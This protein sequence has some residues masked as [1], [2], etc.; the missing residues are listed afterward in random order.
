METGSPLD[1][2]PDL[3]PTVVTPL[4]LGASEL[5][6]VSNLLLQILS[7]LTVYQSLPDVPGLVLTVRD[8]VL[9][10][11]ACCLF[12]PCQSSTVVEI[13][14]TSTLQSPSA[15]DSPT[16]KANR[17]LAIA[18]SKADDYMFAK[19]LE[20]EASRVTSAFAA[21]SESVDPVGD[22]LSVDDVIFYL[23]KILRKD[24]PT[25]PDLTVRE[26]I[27][28]KRSA[29][30]RLGT[31]DDVA[32][33]KFCEAST[34]VQRGSLNMSQG[35][36]PNQVITG[37]SMNL[38]SSNLMNTEG[39]SFKKSRSGGSCLAAVNSL[40]ERPWQSSLPLTVVTEK[41]LT[42]V[43]GYTT[44]K[45]LMVHV[46]MNCSDRLL[47]PFFTSPVEFESLRVTAEKNLESCP[48][49]D[50]DVANLHDA[51][52]V[53]PTSLL[54]ILVAGRY[55]T[56]QGVLLAEEVLD[57]LKKR[58][59][60]SEELTSLKSVRVR[61]I[62]PATMPSNEKAAV[63]HESDFPLPLSSLLQTLLMSYAD[64]I[65]V[66]SQDEVPMGVVTSRDIWGY[67]MQGT[68]GES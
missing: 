14:P 33:V 49:L 64:A 15:G 43:F 47:E 18:S 27:A 57:Q 44:M 5:L 24:D 59:E 63:L 66:L 1:T 37:S 20:N 29:V 36:Q 4:D 65:I 8:D 48:F 40:L 45:Q 25:I 52:E 12:L 30:F 22:F 9:M 54:A 67:V 56:Y 61:S 13:L 28:G 41:C 19:A 10:L 42:A 46:A 53:L 32:W 7:R 39:S 17:L 50:F 62:M 16:S 21:D 26:W 58:I 31:P 3:Q 60:S 38:S 68:I 34:L 2:P 6:D 35:V 51:I 55:Q 23:R 11:D